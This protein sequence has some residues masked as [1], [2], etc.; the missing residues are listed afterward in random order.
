MKPGEWVFEAHAPVAFGELKQPLLLEVIPSATC[1]TQRGA[2][3]SAR[4]RTRSKGDFGA[5]L[6]YG[7][8][9]TMTLDATVNPDFSQVESDAFEV[10]VNQRFPIFFSEK[11]PFFMEGLGLF[12]LAG[13]GG[14]ST[15]RTAVHTRRIVDPSA[16][17]KLTGTAGRYT[18]ATLM[19][20]DESVP[21]GRKM[22]TIGRGLRNFGDG[23]YVGVLVTDTEFQT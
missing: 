19:A 9:S 4:G 21:D 3:R 8:T 7:I 11:R 5:S 22:F 13:T 15:M 10:E 14:D 12:N 1:L 6:K 16:G 2:L 23:Q 17:V 20:P 18:F